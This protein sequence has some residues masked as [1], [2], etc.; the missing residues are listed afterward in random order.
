MLNGECERTG[1]AWQGARPQTPALR[2]Q[3]RDTSSQNF[4]EIVVLATL[5]VNRSGVRHLVLWIGAN[6]I[7][8]LL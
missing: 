5:S 2:V 8:A 3:R 4:W 6:L 7:V 1:G